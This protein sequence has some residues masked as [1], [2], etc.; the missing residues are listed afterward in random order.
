MNKIP[1]LLLVVFAVTLLSGADVSAGRR[2][3]FWPL[4]TTALTA[5]GLNE[6]VHITN[7]GDGNGRLF[8]VEQGGRIRIIQNGAVLPTPFLDISDRVL[9]SGE[10]GLLSVAFPPGFQDSHFY[11]YYTNR[12]G[13]NVVA[14]LQVTTDPNVAT[15]DPA[16]IV[17]TLN[18][19]TY[20]NHNGG[21]L[22]FGPD[23]YLYIGTGDGGGGGDPQGNAQNLNSLLGKLL[24]I[25]VESGFAPYAIPPDNPFAEVND[26]QGLYLDEIWAYGLRNPWR[27][28]FDRTTGDL[29]VGD[30]G[31]SSYEEVDFQPA[32]SLGGENYG[33]NIMEAS[34]CYNG[35]DCDPTGLTP[36]VA[37]YGR[38]LGRTVT[39]GFIYRG[40]RYPRLQGTYFFGDYAD[41]KIFG[42]RLV[43]GAWESNWLMETGL[44][45]STFGE[46]EQGNLYFADYA[47]GDIYLLQALP[48]LA[49]IVRLW[50]V[51]A[52]APGAVAA[53]WAGVMNTDV[54]LLPQGAEVR[55]WVD[56]PGWPSSSSH[57]VGSAPADGLK[58]GA[59]FWYG[60]SWLAPGN[61]ATGLYTYRAQVWLGDTPISGMSEDQTFELT[62][63]LP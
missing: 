21:Q 42:L 44:N 2:T 13:N 41:G 14:R 32:S 23:G 35:A 33:W 38:T 52:A 54:N 61:A 58:P 43:D 25:D 28:S 57:W 24:R 46:D 51:D 34:H 48:E 6:P 17:L 55:F 59:A 12:D 63:S 50:P 36:P 31:Q 40:A 9:F 10:Q 4:L 30:V 60:F 45:I 5:S 3:F 37:E 22:A 53:L 1:G 20:S 16:D 18:H 19:P 8:V 39:G 26:P 11:V 7:A 47:A 27:F 49:G 56:G 15:A 29:Y 62:N